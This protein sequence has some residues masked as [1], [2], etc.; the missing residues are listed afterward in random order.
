M[1]SFDIFITEQIDK[2]RNNNHPILLVK[3]MLETFHININQWMKEYVSLTSDANTKTTELDNLFTKINTSGYNVT[4]TSIKLISDC[5]EE[6]RYAFK[7][8]N[9][10]DIS[11]DKIDDILCKIFNFDIMQY[12]INAYTEYLDKLNIIT[13]YINSFDDIEDRIKLEPASKRLKRF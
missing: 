3:T 11:D 2:C 4:C 9:N 13:N 5:Q 8:C 7:K 6:I 1:N 10:Y 12:Y